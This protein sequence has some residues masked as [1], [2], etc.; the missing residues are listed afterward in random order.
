MTTCQKVCQVI[1]CITYGIGILGLLVL[2]VPLSP[3]MLM[4]WLWSKVEECAKQG[5]KIS[6]A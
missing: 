6:H 3:C 2:F 4:G 1:V 5:E